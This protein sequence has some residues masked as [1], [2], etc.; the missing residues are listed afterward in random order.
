[1]CVF[2]FLCLLAQG[3]LLQAADQPPKRVLILHSFGRE[4]APFET[5]T[6]A[7]R[8][9]LAQRSPE[10]IEF[11]EA[12]VETAR[13]K[14][15]GDDRL[16]IEYLKALFAQRRL[17]LILAV[18][19]PAT[20]FCVRHRS[21]FFPDTPL[22]ADVDHRQ[23]PFV[24]AA[25]N[26][27]ICPDYIKIPPLIDNI[28]QVLPQT[29]N[30]VMVLGASPMERYWA[31]QCRHDFAEFT[32][33]ISFTYVN[34]LSMSQID[35]CV[36]TLPPN[37]A[38]LYGML[39]VDAVGVPYEQ[40]K[41][42]AALHA[43]A[44]APVFGVF[45]SHL[46]RGIVG[47]PLLSLDNSGRTAAG[48]ALHLLRGE[49]AANMEIPPPEPVKRAYDWRELKRWGI[50]EKNLP[51]G[52][53]IRFRVPTF[54]EQ[55]KWRLIA[56][57]VVCLLEAALIVWLVRSRRRLRR[58]QTELRD[59]EEKLRL[60][61]EAAPNGIVLSDERGRIVIVNSQTEKLF[62]YR[63]EELI[64]QTVE[65]FVPE[66]LRAAHPGH[67]AEFLR[68]P[69]SRAMGAGR[70]LFA[71]RKDGSEFPIEIG[72]SPIHTA[73]G[74]LI[75]TVIVDITARKQA[76]AEAQ[77][78]RAE[79]AHVARVSTM[80]ELAASVA[81]ELN[82]PLGAI[83]SNAEAAELFLNHNPPALEE[84]RSILVDIRNDDER[85]G[86]VIQRMHGLLRRRELD[87]QPMVVNSLVED[88]FHL[89]STDA[90]LRKVSLSAD[91]H[92]KP[93]PVLGDRIHLQQV[94]INLILNG[95]EAMSAL[96]PEKRRLVVRAGLNQ[97]RMAEIAVIDTGHGIE[98]HKAPHLFEPFF[99]TKQNGMGM[100]LSIARRIVEAH[101][102]RIS[103]ENNPAGG[104]IFR[105]TLPLAPEDKI[106]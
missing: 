13:F 61:L 83:L 80:G 73:G 25:T 65:V 41:A 3:T 53:E 90:S 88:V 30:I 4:F 8:T 95:M 67:R 74:V 15:G 29:T 97:E 47:G 32:N 12:S 66:R 6:S 63:R 54:W 64:G 5:I 57:Y 7:F 86:A 42:L 96:P 79:L 39:A 18:A 20:D 17:D 35:Q 31:N 48:M 50:S 84:L 93:L 68:A 75:L 103:A 91:V 45:E 24:L 23:L 87:K 62:G 9:E 77:R 14:E 81:H 40:E 70:E 99:T 82:Q 71:R 60:M 104:A 76:E 1:M 59:S 28:L 19:E 43:A 34:D 22:L 51:P 37:S 38:V 105:F 2:V 36:S 11:F 101:G 49:K 56:I 44:N 33:R 89:T 21:E 16:L 69:Q 85:A 102:G 10:P 26:A 52:S 46:G 55:Y 72:L 94:L 92:L 98:P 78:Q 27:T 58:A 106:A 100:G